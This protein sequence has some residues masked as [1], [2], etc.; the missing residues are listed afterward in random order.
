RGLR[1][2]VAGRSAAQPPQQG[3]EIR[4]PARRGGV[5]PPQ[6]S[7]PG[8]QCPLG[9]ARV[10]LVQLVLQ[11]RSQPEVGQHQHTARLVVPDRLGAHPFLRGQRG[12]QLVARGLG[13]E[14]RLSSVVL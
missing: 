8:Q 10:P 4:L 6:G 2:V 13:S 12:E 11:R 9:G 5:H 14:R 1:L 3:D 7:R